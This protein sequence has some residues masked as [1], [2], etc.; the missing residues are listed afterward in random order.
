MI[1]R[2]FG[3]HNNPGTGIGRFGICHGPI[4]AA[5]DDFGIIVKGRGGHAAKPHDTIDP[6]V[7]AAQIIIGIQTLVSRKTN[8]VESLVISVTKFNAVCDA[9]AR[10][11]KASN[12]LE[13]TS[14]AQSPTRNLEK[15]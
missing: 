3:M 6:V 1:S 8:A 4:M 12:Q 11:K 15:N 5:Q 2:V 9:G 10:L 7:I 13:T 14:W